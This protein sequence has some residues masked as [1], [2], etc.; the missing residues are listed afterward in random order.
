MLRHDIVV[1][2]FI[3]NLI[4]MVMRV[5]YCVDWYI[6]KDCCLILSSYLFD[7]PKQR[8]AKGLTYR[9]NNIITNMI[10]IADMRTRG[11]TNLKFLAVGIFLYLIPLCHSEWKV[12]EITCNIEAIITNSCLSSLTFGRLWWLEVRRKD[13]PM[14]DPTGR[15]PFGKVKSCVWNNF[16][17]FQEKIWMI[18]YRHTMY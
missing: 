1:F 9:Y 13:I 7:P 6:G 16:I 3:H 2:S 12:L 8:L 17:C 10:F 4:C 14:V 11:R 18:N 15:Q 5:E